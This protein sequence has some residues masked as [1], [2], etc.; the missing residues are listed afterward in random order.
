MGLATVNRITED[1]T[2]VF[3]KRGRFDPDHAALKF[4]QDCDV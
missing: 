4:T 2:E 3:A 1:R